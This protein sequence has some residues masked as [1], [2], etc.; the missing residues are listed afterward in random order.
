M[1]GTDPNT[2]HKLLNYLYWLK[3]RGQVFAT[4]TSQTQ[5]DSEK[6]VKVELKRLPI[7]L[8]F[9]T[10]DTLLPDEEQMVHRIGFALGLSTD[11]FKIVQDSV[12]DTYIPS[13]IVVMG[14][15]K[16]IGSS[17]IQIPHP[18]D[19]LSTPQLK[20]SAWE[21]LQRLKGELK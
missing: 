10:P 3:D 6:D 14:E 1:Q 7:K 8:L 11:H 5:A 13:F 17:P 18:R 20:V 19:M 21:K 9:L 12:A 15:A 16:A 2:E 4:E